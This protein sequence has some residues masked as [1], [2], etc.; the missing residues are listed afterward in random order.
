MLKTASGETQKGSLFGALR[1][2]ADEIKE[3]KT[4]A[5]EGQVKAGETPTPPDP[6]GYQGASTHPTTN[7]DNSAQTATEGARSSENTSDV[8]A[9][10]KEPAVDNT[11]EATPNQDEQDSVQLNIGTQQ[12]AT[13]EDPSVEDDYKG[14]KDDPGSSM[15][16]RT[17]NNPEKY[18]S[19]SFKEAHSRST[20][21]AN[22][23][24]ADLANGYGEQLE[25]GAESSDP[26]SRPETSAPMT[27]AGGSAEGEHVQPGG[28]GATKSEKKKEKDAAA[29]EPPAGIDAEAFQKASAA[30]GGQPQVE[31]MQAGY[32]LA[33]ALGISKEAAAQSVTDTIA[34]TI[35]DAQLDADLFGSYYS[36]FLEKQSAVPPDE[37]GGEDHGNPNDASSGAG[38]AAEPM[39]EDMG[40]EM[41]PEMMGGAE[42]GGPSLGDLL[43]PG[44]EGG[45]MEGGMGMEGM[46]GGE[47]TEEEAVAELA[48]AL[49]ELGIPLEALAEAGG[50]GMPPEGGGE[51][52]M[53]PP[54]GG[55]MEVAASDKSTPTEGQKL[56]SAIQ[57]FKQAGKYQFKQANDGT[58]ARAIRDI[59]KGYLQEI[60]G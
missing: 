49:D 44:G 45:G 59:M 9:D 51:P 13:G 25:K 43:G 42:E 46:P 47:P 58:R 32:E 41:P 22:E 12:S 39:P 3:E 54:E 16:A 37:E 55:G 30:V 15:P 17:D 4:A 2:L 1:N 33:A 6:G 28:G 27:P 29:Q 20:T 35:Q 24:L 18:G 7:V 23:L 26:K 19:L 52:M 10:Q 8:K 34:A 40:G 38:E 53:P 57:R 50:G 36:A 48:A 21:L 11:S 56:A 14:E 60:M 31:E 5:A